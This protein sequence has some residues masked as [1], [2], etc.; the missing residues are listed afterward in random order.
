[1][2]CEIVRAARRQQGLTEEAEEATQGWQQ[3]PP[4]GD[5]S[6]KA[7]AESRQRRGTKGGTAEEAQKKVKKKK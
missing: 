5:H 6:R 4:S 7:E 2:V 1:M 3:G